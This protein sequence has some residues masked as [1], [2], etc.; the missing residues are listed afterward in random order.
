MT[1]FKGT[2]AIQIFGLIMSMAEC[3]RLALCYSCYELDFYI[4]FIH[5]T[6]CMVGDQELITKHLYAFLYAGGQI[7]YLKVLFPQEVLQKYL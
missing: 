6:S 5:L 7:M 4:V 3:H 1:S 2:F